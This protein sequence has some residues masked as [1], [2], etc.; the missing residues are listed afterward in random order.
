MRLADLNEF[1]S[2]YYTPASAPA[3]ATLRQRIRKGQIPGGQLDGGRFMVDLDEYDRVTKA[4][5]QIEERHQR[6]LKSSVLRG[7]I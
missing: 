5:C 3:V 7:L 4:R 1:R 2:L 6:L